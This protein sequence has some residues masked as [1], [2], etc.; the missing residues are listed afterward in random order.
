MRHAYARIERAR[1]MGET[2]P[3]KTYSVRDIE[4]NSRALAALKRQ[5]AHTFLAGEQVF[6]DPITGK[7]YVNDKPP[8][9]V[10][11]ASPKGA[12]DPPPPGLP[13]AA[14]VRH[15]EPDGRR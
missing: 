11:D 5:K 9:L 15:A 1:V 14:Y 4:L 2:K 3:T 8:R 10:W 6:L 7:P 13:D 12:R